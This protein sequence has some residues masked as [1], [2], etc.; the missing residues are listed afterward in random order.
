MDP[1][2][3]PAERRRDVLKTQS[4]DKKPKRKS[5]R[6]VGVPTEIRTV[7]LG[8]GGFVANA[9][10]EAAGARLKK[11]TDTLIRMEPLLPDGYGTPE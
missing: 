8:H 1:V 2:E 4:P 7:R 3:P 5:P 11:A 10:T 9:H 6:R